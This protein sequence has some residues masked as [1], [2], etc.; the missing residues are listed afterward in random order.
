[1]SK[2]LADI[3]QEKGIPISF[4]YGGKSPDEMVSREIQKEP[5]PRAKKMRDLYFD[6]LSSATVEFP[7]WYTR[8]YEELEHE[9]PVVRRAEALKCA[10]SHLTPTIWPG[11]LLVMGKTRY[12][13]GSFPLPWL[14]EGYFMA[15]EDELYQSAL[16]KGGASADEVTKWGAGGGN[17]TEDFG[18]V[19]SIAG[20]FGI[21]NE[22]VP[23]LLRLARSW[24]GKSVDD[25]SNKYERLVPEYEIKENIMRSVICMFDSGY[26][27]PQ[28]P[29]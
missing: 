5:T 3:L 29:K 27:L 26:T 21:R 14:S 23:A 17:V 6:T 1:M 13:R 9:I 11:E 15:R 20:K 7:Y 18:N 24:V 28:G 8:K 2:T 12:Y 25:L 16:A 10:F 19:V 22:E 4:E